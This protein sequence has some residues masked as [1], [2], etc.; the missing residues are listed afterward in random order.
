MVFPKL[1]VFPVLLELQAAMSS[2]TNTWVTPCPASKV[3]HLP[4]PGRVHHGEGTSPMPTGPG[5]PLVV[6]DRVETPT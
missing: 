1:P 6:I 4:R 2:V 3:Q 5:G